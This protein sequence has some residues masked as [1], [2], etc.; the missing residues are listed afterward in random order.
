MSKNDFALWQQATGFVY[1]P[2]ALIFDERMDGIVFPLGQMLHD[3][4]HAFLVKS[5][6][7]TC[8]FLMLTSLERLFNKDVYSVL[9]NYMDAWQLPANR[10]E[11]LKFMTFK[12]TASEGLPLYPIFAFFLQAVVTPAGCCLKECTAFVL[13]ADVLDCIQAVPHGC[14]T[15]ALLKQSIHEFLQACLDC[16]WEGNM[17]SKFHWLIHFPRHLEQF[18]QL[19]SC[20]VQERKHKVVKRYSS[21]ISNTITFE[22]SMM[23]EI[24]SHDLAKLKLPGTFATRLRLSKS[25]QPAKKLKD[26]LDTVF[27]PQTGGQGYQ[28][29]AD[30]VL[31]SGCVCHKG[32]ICI[33]QDNSI[34]AGQIW[35]HADINGKLMSLISECALMEYN[36][37]T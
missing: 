16:K 23:A 28:T 36:P 35:V 14:I 18:L 4:M 24:L 20:F 13:L 3:W 17:H 32:D 26:L 34:K 12:C 27:G 8:M 11:N 22:K 15:S 33:L 10:H 25:C 7:Q 37:K 30:L 19:P 2:T 9:H 21:S 5:V 1:N 6:F 31:S 29:C